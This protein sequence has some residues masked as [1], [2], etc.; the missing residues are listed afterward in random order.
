MSNKPLV[1]QA[2]Y[3]KMIFAFL[4]GIAV[5]LFSPEKNNTLLLFTFMPLSVMCT[6]NVEYS[7]SKMYQEIVLWLMLVG[8][9]LCF[10]A[11][12]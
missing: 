8:S 9:V 1:I 12:L 2:S 7:K 3:K 5:F 11:Q 10:F 4:I 6:N